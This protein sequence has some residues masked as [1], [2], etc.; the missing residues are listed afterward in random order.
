MLTNN[1]VIANAVQITVTPRDGRQLEAEIIGSDS[2]TDVAAVKIPAEDLTDVQ[3]TNSD[4]LRVGDFAVAI[5]NP[6]GLGQTVTSGI[7][8]TLS[9]SGLDIEGYEDFIQTDASINPG[10]SGGAMVNLRGELVRIN[11]AIFFKVA[12][13]SRLVLL[14]S[15]TSPDK[16]LTRSLT[17]VK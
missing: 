14:S 7:V 6:F 2:E 11:T 9:R 4:K 5:D 15:S 17:M 3:A 1:H 13:I 10:N 16:L 12:E 8:S